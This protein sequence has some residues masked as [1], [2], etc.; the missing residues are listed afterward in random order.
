MVMLGLDTIRELFA[1]RSTFGIQNFL[2][3][4]RCFYHLSVI[5][6]EAENNPFALYMD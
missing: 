2:N 6:V 5:P 1:Y 4:F 3:I